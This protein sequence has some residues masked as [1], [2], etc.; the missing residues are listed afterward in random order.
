[1]PFS[2]PP[3]ACA[4]NGP[5]SGLCVVEIG[6]VIAAPFATA[7]LADLGADVV[8]IERPQI[9]DD[10]RFM[11]PAFRHG[12]SL[13]FHIFNR[14]KRSVVLD[15][16]SPAGHAD[17]LRLLERAD[18]LVH[19]LRPGAA[20]KLGLEL[21]DL[22]ERFPRLV[23][24]AISA[25]GSSGPLSASPGYE[26]LV[27]AFSGMFSVN[28]GPG[29]PPMRIGPSVC[30]QGA[31]MW[32]VIG[33]MARLQERG[34][35]GRGGVVETSLLETALTWL[36][37]K[38]D[39]FINEGLAPTRHA[40]G[41]PD[42]VPYQRFDA[43]DGPLLICAG[44]DR[45]FAKLAATLGRPDWA[46]DARFSTNRARL[47]HKETLVKKID[48]LVRT[49]PRA[50]WMQRFSAAGVPH[51]PIHTIDEVV[52]HP[53]VAALQLRQAVPGTDFGLVA[54]PLLF[55]GRRL[56]LRSEAPRLG[57]HNDQ[58]SSTSME[59]FQ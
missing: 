52:A 28:G 33:I 35:T 8:K 43:A 59:H 58:L 7:I 30:D 5:L 55:D 53:Q 27:Q 1:M 17:A 19:N 49:Q 48:A 46:Q 42:F 50:V 3:N 25:F 15:L 2:D 47:A 9:G 6:Q 57:E 21:T 12:D 22:C 36:G 18:V 34:R 24:C 37:P 44:N 11:G 16:Q 41:H 40:S 14:G 10:A 4:P 45:L 26:P 20:A 54:T 23:C 32:A 38:L 31:G 29:D 51:S 13:N 39:S 56:P